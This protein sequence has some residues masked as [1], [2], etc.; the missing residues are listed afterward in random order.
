V[1]TVESIPDQL[2]RDA[3]LPSDLR[4]GASRPRGRR[5]FVTGATGFLGAYVVRE[6]LART[7]FE[8]VC[9]VRT[10]GGPS[11]PSLSGPPRVPASPRIRCVAGHLA[12]P[13]LGL[14]EAAFDELAGSIDGIVH[15]AALVNWLLPYDTTR[16]PNVGG[17]LEI[18]RL[19]AAAGLVPI[20]HVS[21]TAVFSPLLRARTR[22]DEAEPLPR[23]TGVPHMAD[24]GYLRSKW[25]AERA[26]AR[27][28][29][30]GIPA[31]IYRPGFIVG[32]SRTGAWSV[33]D[34][35]PRLL[36]GCAQLGCAPELPTLI[37]L[38]PV[39]VVAAELVRRLAADHADVVHLVDRPFISYAQLWDLVRATGRP[40]PVVPYAEWRA[41][42]LATGTTDNPIVP[43]TPF[44]TEDFDMGG[45]GWN[46]APFGSVAPDDAT[47]V[48]RFLPRILG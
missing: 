27:A 11:G 41:R 35:L 46:V 40:W 13:R 23:W 25:A 37:N 38:S 1:A 19:S 21:T 26:M 14:A 36:R 20:H 43:M 45:T 32:D 48:T 9:L 7:D 6:L 30:I 16:A 34:F 47:L 33:D 8:L 15:G 10:R 44:F 28:R 4:V 18:I 3:E 42:L 29:A 2:E 5:L 22:F 39:D 24:T 12:K 31:R 17:T